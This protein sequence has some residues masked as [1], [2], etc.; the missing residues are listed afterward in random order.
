MPKN[1]QRISRQFPCSLNWPKLKFLFSCWS[2]QNCLRRQYW[3]SRG[4]CSCSSLIGQE[5][6]QA[7]NLSQ[8]EASIHK[9][10]C[11]WCLKFPKLLEGVTK[12]TTWY[13]LLIPKLQKVR[14]R[15]SFRDLIKNA[16]ANIVCVCEENW[17]RPHLRSCSDRRIRCRRSWGLRLCL[18]MCFLHRKHFPHQLTWELQCVCLMP[19][20]NLRGG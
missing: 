3:Q 10:F 9:L 14:N 18:L 13:C 20:I 2:F 5:L 8:W 15:S 16:V 7:S 19:R 6:G 17:A 1:L 11:T 12:D 4:G